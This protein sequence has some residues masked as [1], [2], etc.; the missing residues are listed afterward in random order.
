[1]RM[2]EDWE[3]VM[4]EAFGLGIKNG[5]V[6]IKLALYAQKILRVV[7]NSLKRKEMEK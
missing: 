5:A 2:V 7:N 1:M 4:D 3:L 6:I